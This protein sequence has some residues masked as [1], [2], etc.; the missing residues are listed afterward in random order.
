MTPFVPA[1]DRGLLL[2]DGLFET[3]LFKDGRAVLWAEHLSRL[4]RGCVALGLPPPDETWLADAAAQAMSDLGATRAAVRLTWTAGSG[5]RGLERPEEAAPRL[6]ASAVVSP[7]PSTPVTLVIS[8]VRRNT[9]SPAS[10]LKTLSYL[11]NV[12][13]RREAVASGSDE[14]L[15]LNGE[16]QLACASAANLFWIGQGRI[17]TPALRCGVLD[18]VIRAR[19]LT[20]A[21]A[22]GVAVEEVAAPASALDKAQ[23]LFLTNSLI[24]VRRV[25]VLDGQPCGE[26][27]VIEALQSALEAVT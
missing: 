1:D 15:M 20:A 19:V 16:G 22:M 17:F 3:I 9:G 10:R 25:A 26:H 13:A 4:A 8:S 11:D 5:G 21:A 23:A 14:A 27:P 2:G 6:I 12:L 18:G 7:R 24:G